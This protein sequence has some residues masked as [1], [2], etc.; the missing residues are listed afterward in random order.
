M[1]TMKY[2]VQM[3]IWTLQRKRIQAAQR[4]RILTGANYALAKMLF[5]SK[6]FQEVKKKLSTRESINIR[7]YEWI[8]IFLLF[9]E[10]VPVVVEEIAHFSVYGWRSVDMFGGKMLGLFCQIF[11]VRLSLWN[12]PGGFLDLRVEPGWIVTF[13]PINYYIGNRVLRNPLHRIG[14]IVGNIILHVNPLWVDIASYSAW[15]DS[16]GSQSQISLE[17]YRDYF[18]GGNRGRLTVAQVWG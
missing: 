6:I 15:K 16:A 13:F 1:R 7:Y 18:H 2:V 4:F 11:G 5:V 9:Q 17:E 14:R 3:I 12:E 8:S 10:V